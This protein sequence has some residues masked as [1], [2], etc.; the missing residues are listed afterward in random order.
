MKRTYLVVISSVI[1]ITVVIV[2]TLIQVRS[3]R[4]GPQ[5][6]TPTPTYSLDPNATI[7]FP[8]RPT[9]IQPKI[10]DLAPD[11]PYEDKPSV[12]VQHADGSRERY[13]LA[14]DMLDTFIKNL[15]PGDKFVGDIPPPSASMTH[16]APLSTAEESRPLIM[17]SG[18]PIKVTDLSPEVADEDK[19]TL[20]IRHADGSEEAFLI[21]PDLVDQFISQLPKE[22]KLVQIISPG[23]IESAHP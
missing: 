16:E 4:S 19:G 17:R 11:I 10:V 18:V 6:S 20:I 13:L 1:I 15:P 9:A 21:A 12:V 23:S 8:I 2:L 7:V 22:D 3:V 5:A 14:P